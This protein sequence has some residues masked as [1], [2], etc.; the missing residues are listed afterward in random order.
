MIQHHL[1]LGSLHNILLHTVFSDEP[2]DRHLLLLPDPVSTSLSLQVVL[3]IPVTIKYN[4]CVSSGEVDA[5][6]TSACGEQKT[7]VLKRRC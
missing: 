4:D 5:K 7:E 3:G 1:F 6:T 2:I